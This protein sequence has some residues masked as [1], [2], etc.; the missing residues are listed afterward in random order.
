MKFATII[1]LLGV[2]SAIKLVKKDPLPEQPNQYGRVC[3][4]VDPVNKEG[5]AAQKS[6]AQK[7]DPLPEQP[8]QYNRVCDAVDPVNKEGCAAQITKK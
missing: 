4:A 6:L 5:C 7:K 2:A 8:N 3:D 1:A